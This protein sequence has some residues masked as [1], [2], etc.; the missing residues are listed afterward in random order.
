MVLV[1]GTSIVAVVMPVRAAREHERGRKG[2]S[3][4]YRFLHCFLLCFNDKFS[5]PDDNHAADIL[6]DDNTP[7][8]VVVFRCRAALGADNPIGRAN[9]YAV[10][11]NR[12]DRQDRTSLRIRE[13]RDVQRHIA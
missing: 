10:L 6:P 4:H 13:R 9:G 5:S 3:Q 1:A 7:V 8:G 12:E 2:H 11:A